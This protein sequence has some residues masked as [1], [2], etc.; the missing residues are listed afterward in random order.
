M[1]ASTRAE[2]TFREGTSA[3]GDPR[4]LQPSEIDQVAGGTRSALL[5]R[6]RRN[7]RTKPVR[8]PT[9]GAIAF[10]VLAGLF[11]LGLAALR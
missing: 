6:R 5:G 7:R 4:Y 3:F 9:A 11:V 8:R 10:C 2:P 1:S